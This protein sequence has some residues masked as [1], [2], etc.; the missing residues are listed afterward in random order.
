M[1]QHVTKFKIATVAFPESF[2]AFSKFLKAAKAKKPKAKTSCKF[3]LLRQQ[4]STHNELIFHPI[5]CSSEANG[6]SQKN[7]QQKLTKSRKKYYSELI[8]R[9]GPSRWKQREEFHR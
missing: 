8:I 2:P 6:G 1:T 9:T 5:H 3:I 7:K 4:L